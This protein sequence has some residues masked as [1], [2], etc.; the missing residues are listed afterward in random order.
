MSGKFLGNYRAKVIDNE[1][2]IQGESVKSGRIKVRVFGVHDEVDEEALPWAIYADPFMGGGEDSGGFFV[3]DIGDIVWVFFEQGDHDQPVYFAGA[4]SRN[5]MPSERNVEDYPKNRVLKTKAGFIFEIDDSENETRLKIT[6]PSGNVKE[7]DHEGN[8]KEN[9][10]GDVDENIEGDVTKTIGGNLTINVEGGHVI[11]N[12]NDIRL[13]DESD[14]E[15]AVLGEQLAA[16]AQ[17]L[18][19]WLN[20]HNHIGNLGS[21]TSAVITPFQIGEAAQGNSV[22]SKK[23][24]VQP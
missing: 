15:S 19:S 17:Q 8:V 4:P 24:K 7:S 6:Q 10:V 3:P 22:Y 13:G 11:I 16:W 2:I 14:L 5:D 21:P 9:I 12:S 20:S 18:T 1:D 23:V